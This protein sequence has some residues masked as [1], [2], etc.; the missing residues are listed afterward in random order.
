M[1][2][3]GAL[4][5]VAAYREAVEEYSPPQGVVPREQIDLVRTRYEFQIFPTLAPGAAPPSP[6]N[7]MGGRFSA[8]SSAFAIT[9]IAMV[10]DGDIVM[11]TTT[12]QADLVL[13]DL[14]KA[15]D[16]NLGYRL[17]S[18][19]KTK[20]YVSQV[21]VE[22]DDP[23]EKSFRIFEKIINE[24]NLCRL[25]KEPFNLKRIGF[26]TKDSV[27]APSPILAVE[28]TEFTIERRADHP[29]DENRYFCAAPMTT[30][31]HIALLQRIEEIIKAPI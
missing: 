8:G 20:S 25:N 1:K 22:F 24:I 28:R 4:H 26:G 19:N 13:E 9:Q 3:I 17:A 12:E 6:L 16:E 31:E 21:V 15:L 2:L 14:I 10:P 18:A 27:V 23:L 7:F 11:A 5:G 30:T 29:F